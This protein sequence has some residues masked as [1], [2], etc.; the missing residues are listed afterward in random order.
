[1]NPKI[2]SETAQLWL[3]EPSLIGGRFFQ[4][5]ARAEISATLAATQGPADED[6]TTKR[7]KIKAYMSTFYNLRESM[8]V[9]NGI[10]TIHA[11]G[12]LLKDA[13][14]I[15]EILGATGYESLAAD[16]EAAAADESVKG[17]LLKV[18]SPGGMAM[19]APEIGDQV[20]ELAQSKPVVAYSPDIMASAAYYIS[21][22]ATAIIASPSAAVGSIGT[23]AQIL[24]VTKLYES[25]G[26]KIETFTPA[27]S[28]LKTTGH[29]TVA[30]TDKQREHMQAHVEAINGGF[31]G[32]VRANRPAVTAAEMRGQTYRGEDAAGNGLADA[33]GSE[34]DALALLQT[35]LAVDAAA[36]A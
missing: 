16:L 33:T 12:P 25:M 4:P 2:L 32:F 9:E 8:S 28:D 29:P 30:L 24:D 10:A 21:A 18:Q 17:I 26:V 5:N 35:L 14:F 27:Q 23:L 1:M 15:D 3:I 13:S 22:G 31:T 6:K 20:R 19:G 36:S 11:Y 7:Q 34:K